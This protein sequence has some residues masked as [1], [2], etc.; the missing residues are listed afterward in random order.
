[1]KN[2]GQ[3]SICEEKQANYKCPK[4]LI[5][6]CSLLCYKSPKHDHTESQGAEE[7]TTKDTENQTNVKNQVPEQAKIAEDTLKPEE[8]KKGNDLQAPLTAKEQ[9]FAKMAQDPQIK[10]LLSCKSLQVHLAVLIKLLEDSLLTN[11][12]MAENRREIANMRLCEL[13]K[14]GKEENSLIE[15][16]VERI[17]QL[18]DDLRDTT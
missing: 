8:T 17:L 1:M 16:F 9:L 4:C 5:V 18:Q 12:P 6:Y 14:G 13:R 11:E 15:E 10:S 7:Q 2:L 3:C